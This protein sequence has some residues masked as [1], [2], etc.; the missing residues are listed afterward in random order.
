MSW[1]RRFSPRRSLDGLSGATRV[2]VEGTIV[3]ED[4]VES[5]MTGRRGALIEYGFWDLRIISFGP[6]GRERGRAEFSTRVG[7]DG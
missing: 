2:T 7:A 3:A 4:L 5:W 6:Y 1:W